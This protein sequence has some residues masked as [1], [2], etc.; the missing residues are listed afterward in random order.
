MWRPVWGL[1]AQEGML[2]EQEGSS[3]TNPVKS[4]QG[5]EGL[6]GLPC[7][8]LGLGLLHPGGDVASGMS[9]RG[10]RRQGLRGGVCVRR[11]RDSR[12]NRN[13][14]SQLDIAER[15]FTVRP[16]KCCLERL[17]G[18]NAWRFPRPRWIKL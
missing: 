15:F 9:G 16:V 6:E 3:G 18:L 10:L 11:V 14:S 12:H 2:L 13:Q 1:P 8:A 7:R 4:C 5:G 17:R